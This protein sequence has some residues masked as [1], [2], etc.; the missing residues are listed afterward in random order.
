MPAA[1]SPI[2]L[3]VGE[4]SHCKFFPAGKTKPTKQPCAKRADPQIASCRR[5]R[6][7]LRAFCWQSGLLLASARRRASER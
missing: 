3:D 2:A 6:G 7:L 1:K 5:H 4:R